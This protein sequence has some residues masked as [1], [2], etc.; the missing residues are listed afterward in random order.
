MPLERAE[1]FEF[2]LPR[3]HGRYYSRDEVLVVA[4]ILDFYRE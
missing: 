2:Y 1:Q 3:V 4:A